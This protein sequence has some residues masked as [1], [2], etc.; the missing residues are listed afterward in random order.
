[1][2][3]RGQAVAHVDHGVQIDDGMKLKGFAHPRR[4]RQVSSQD[5]AAEGS[6]YHEPIPRLRAAA[7]YRAPSGRL[8]GDRDGD[9]EGAVPAIGI[10]A[11]DRRVESIGG[12]AQTK[13]KFFRQLPP[14]LTR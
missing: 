6:G 8:S 1:M 3:V 2:D 4:D 11:H 10:T 12:L 9:H 7:P 5:A 14:S 13:I